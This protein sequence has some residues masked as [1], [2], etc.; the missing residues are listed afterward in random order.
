MRRG[1]SRPARPHSDGRKSRINRNNGAADYCRVMASSK[2]PPETL[3]QTRDDVDELP[4]NGKDCMP[5]KDDF[6]RGPITQA[7]LVALAGVLGDNKL[8]SVARSCA[9]FD[10]LAKK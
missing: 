8:S 9:L 6:R 5:A 3:A 4:V 10:G 2:F 7:A 1:R